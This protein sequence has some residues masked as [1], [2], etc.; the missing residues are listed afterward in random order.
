MR[1]VSTAAKVGLW[2]EHANPWIR[3]VGGS[4]PIAL[5]FYLTALL[6]YFVRQSLDAKQ[7]FGV[8]S[9]LTLVV[10]I[11]ISI[12]RRYFEL[13]IADF[14]RARDVERSIVGQSHNFSD[15]LIA[16]D[17]EMI[18]SGLRTY[19]VRHDGTPLFQAI[20]A[21]RERISFIVERL[22][23]ALEAQYSQTQDYIS[24]S[25]LK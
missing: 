16:Q 9:G 3:A 7:L 12:A 13:Q 1:R 25:I 20:V 21:S 24:K 8:L 11:V 23:L 19:E 14:K 4:V 6:S 15:Q 18:R 22:Y 2:Y 17:C 5:T 10:I